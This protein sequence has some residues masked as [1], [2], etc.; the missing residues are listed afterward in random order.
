MF[1][2]VHPKERK[3]DKKKFISL[4]LRF[5]RNLV[6]DFYFKDWEII[7]NNWKVEVKY[8]YKICSG[9]RYERKDLR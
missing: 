6:K 9:S 5:I 7:E 4:L 3:Q 8:K 2:L 1:T